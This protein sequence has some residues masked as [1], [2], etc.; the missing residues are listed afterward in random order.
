LSTYILSVVLV[1]LGIMLNGRMGNV[2]ITGN[3][4][5]GNG[6]QQEFPLVQFD[7]PSWHLPGGTE[8]N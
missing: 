6:Q 1:A 4:V 3:D 7:A 2:V 5:E 8:E